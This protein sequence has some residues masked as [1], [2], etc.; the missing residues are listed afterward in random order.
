ML[1]VEGLTAN[2]IRISQLCDQGMNVHF[3][4]LK[5]IVTSSNEEVLM[6]CARSNDNLLFV[7]T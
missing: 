3:N 2:L 6:K 7:G 1:L 4:K 5:C